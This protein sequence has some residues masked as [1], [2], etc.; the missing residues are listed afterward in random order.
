[1][2]S[3]EFWLRGF[4]VAAILFSISLIAI[5]AIRGSTID[6]YTI[7]ATLGSSLLGA[8]I[9]ILLDRTSQ[10]K[11]G[12]RTLAAIENRID[13][14]VRAL[15]HEEMLTSNIDQLKNIS[16]LWHQYNVT[17]K[18]GQ[19]YWIH[20]VY[21][22]QCTQNGEIAF[23]V[24]YKDNNNNTVKYNYE[25]AIRDDRTIFIGKP[26]IG[27]Q[28]CFVEIWPHL[29]NAAI[30]CHAGFCFNQ[31]WD[32]HDSVVPCLLSR[33]PLT[34]KRVIDNEHLDSLWR[35]AVRLQHTLLFPRV[36]P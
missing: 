17:I 28:P 14:F 12:D 10:Q 7:A 35:S 6:W 23:T 11:N 27:Q 29:S 19:Y 24:E 8:A 22:I 26:E 2:R 1:M 33:K 16:G 32:L 4:L 15:G 31:S 25:G 18:N 3:N 36:T 21:D 13:H 30:Q 20:A 5:G 34:G 9:G